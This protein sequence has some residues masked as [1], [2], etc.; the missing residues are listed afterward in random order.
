[1]KN[2]IP[3][4]RLNT[5]ITYSFFLNSYKIFEQVWRHFFCSHVNSLP[6]CDLLPVWR[7][8]TAPP[9]SKEIALFCR[10]SDNS[11]TI[12]WTHFCLFKHYKIII[13]YFVYII[14]IQSLSLND[15]LVA[16]K[17]LSSSVLAVWKLVF[18]E[19][20]CYTEIQVY[21]GLLT[22]SY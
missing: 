7:W 22:T 12:K 8:S 21:K 9:V 18:M 17:C 16:S 19:S 4:S 1:M 5:R 15:I 2:S 6:F 20:T 13:N 3:N 11:V 10:A 14:I